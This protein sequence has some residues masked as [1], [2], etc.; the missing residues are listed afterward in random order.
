MQIKRKIISTFFF[1]SPNWSWNS[2]DV[3]AVTVQPGSGFYTIS[4]AGSQEVGPLYEEFLEEMVS[5]LG[6]KVASWE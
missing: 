2:K 4:G 1:E 5:S 3:I 6:L